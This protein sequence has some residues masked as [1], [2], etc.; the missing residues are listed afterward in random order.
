MNL[1]DVYVCDTLVGTVTPEAD[2]AYVFGYFPD[3]PEDLFVSLT[4]PVRAQSYVWK[5]GL[6][7]FFLMNLPEGYKKDLL[8]EKLGP[9][10]EVTDSNLLAL[11]GQRTIGRVR[12]TP[13][14][15]S[16][17]SAADHIQL[18]EILASPSSRDLLLRSMA[19]GVAEGISGVMPKL[20]HDGSPVATNKKVTS[21]TEHYILKTG[22][23]DLP[24]LSI[25]EY[26]C[27]EVAREAKLVVPMTR[28]S[29]D[30]AVLAIER[31]DRKT[32]GS[33]IAMEDCCAIKG[34]E[35]ASKYSGSLE[36]IAD[37]LQRYVPL[38]A[39]R[40]ASRKLWTLL[41]VNYALGNADAHLKNFAFTYT[42]RNDV[43]I[44]PAY[45][46]VTVLA[47]AKWKDDLPGL[48]L[49]GKKQWAAGKFLSQL[50]SS[51]LNLTSSDLTELRG[52]VVTA[53]HRVAPSISTYA[54]RFPEFREIGKRML[55]V[56]DQG[57]ACIKPTASAKTHS[58]AALR[59]QSG[60]SEDKPAAKEANPY[61][62]PNGAF[63]HR[64]R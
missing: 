10:T 26:L 63:S 1:L 23:N 47:Y 32:D 38:P 30:G 49:F 59:E 20:L 8:R 6:H 25:N 44:A 57:L 11:T 34:L 9:Q 62:D 24:G 58:Q 19:A 28:L 43:M 7:P 53:I 15:T 39:Q 50:G 45:D 35:P 37:Y 12:V 51:R 2:G 4:M 54:E 61:I 22:P 13:H 52:N 60:F 27:L 48:T 55:D 36:N 17:A 21:V 56:W 40:E 41:L 16:L 42:G 29:E 18:A 33:F 46:I 3:T 64:A 14:G 5:R 31:F